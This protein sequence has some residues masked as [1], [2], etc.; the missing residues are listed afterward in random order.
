MKATKRY[1]KI[2]FLSLLL[3]LVVNFAKAQCTAFFN[4]TTTA[5]CGVVQFTNLST[6]S[7]SMVT[8]SWNFPSAITPTSA[9]QNPTATYTAN[10]TYTVCLFIVSTVPSCS[11]SICKTI[12]V[13]CF[14]SS[15]CTANFNTV[16][17]NSGQM[18]FTNTSLGTNSTTVYNWDFGNSSTSTLT[19]PTATYAT[20]SIYTVCLTYTTF[21]PA[22][23]SASICK[24]V[25]IGCVTSSCNA[26]FIDSACVGNGVI[27]FFDASTGLSA[28]TSYT[29]NFGNSTTSNLQNPLGT[30]TANGTYT[31]CL[32]IT[33]GSPPCNSN[34]CKVITVTCVPTPSCQANFTNSPCNNGQVNFWS[35]SS[36]TTSSTTYS[37]T[38]SSPPSGPPAPYTATV[39]LK[40][41]NLSPAC[42]HSVCKSIL[43]DCTVGIPEF[44][45]ENSN[46]KIFPNPSNGFF[47]LDIGQV[48]SNFSSIHIAV[49]NIFGELV[50]Q[51]V[52]EVQGRKN[53]E[54]DL[55]SLPNGAYYLRLNAGNN[56]YSVKLIIAK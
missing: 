44:I 53:K 14:T 15:L 13:N 54:I 28:P 46:I 36:G 18:T 17:C 10:G 1:I 55:Q 52:E 9:M 22:T 26:N 56:T 47:T 20:N 6:P 25:S 45:F 3:S 24:T 31:V 8:Y 35:T 16:V 12:T 5:T 40:M 33:S 43:I 51:N 42:T 49:Y 50:H 38:Y 48:N 27:P 4:D 39:C 34:I 11:A 29:W 41:I 30:Y 32:S 37:W 21:A 7:N 23:C 2:S 19:S